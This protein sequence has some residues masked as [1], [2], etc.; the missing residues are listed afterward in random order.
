MGEIGLGLPGLLLASLL[1]GMIII[2]VVSAGAENTNRLDTTDGWAEP[3][4]MSMYNKPI[5]TKEPVRPG[6]EDLARHPGMILLGENVTFPDIASAT[7]PGFPSGPTTHV[8]VVD[9]A[10]FSPVP[11]TGEVNLTNLPPLRNYDL[12]TAD[13]GAFVADAGS[14]SP[15]TLCLSGRDFV[16]DL[17]PVPGPVAE[18]AQAFVKNESGTIALALPRIWSFE[19]TVAGEP[20]SFASFT[21]GD[22]VILGTIKS[23]T[24]SLVIAQAGTVEI[25]G[26][27]RIVHVIYDERD[28]IPKFWPLATDRCVPPDG[29]EGSPDVTGNRVASLLKSLIDAMRPGRA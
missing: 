19:G 27:Q 25:D 13:P 22:D 5:V 24:T 4:D 9:P 23:N 12:A 21:V 11:P 14:G 17:E 15:V 26:V 3:R 2:P 18:G 8:A 1:I 16:L 28:V 29:A 10:Y 7:A 20:G 6:P